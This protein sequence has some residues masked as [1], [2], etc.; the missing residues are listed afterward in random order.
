[1]CDTCGYHHVKKMVLSIAEPNLRSELLASYSNTVIK[2]KCQN[3]ICE[4]Q[5][6]KCDRSCCLNPC[7]PCIYNTKRHL[8]HHLGRFHQPPIPKLDT[9]SVATT[10][11]MALEFPDACFHSVHPPC[12]NQLLFDDRSPNVT[13]PP[14]VFESV[15]LEKHLRNCK[16]YGYYGAVCRLVC[17]AAFQD[18]NAVEEDVPNPWLMAIEWAMIVISDWSNRCWWRYHWKISRNRGTSTVCPTGSSQCPSP[19]RQPARHNYNHCSGW[20]AIS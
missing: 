8:V 13:P 10:V 4:A 14:H 17:R 2:H 19:S 6:Y 16:T 15:S 3:D 11:P 18:K 5:K 12:R 1:M 7:V 9:I 20:E